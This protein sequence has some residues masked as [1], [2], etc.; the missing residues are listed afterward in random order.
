MPS[1]RSRSSPTELSARNDEVRVHRSMFSLQQYVRRT[2]DLIFP[3]PF[4]VDQMDM[5]VFVL[6]VD[7]PEELQA[8]IDRELNTPWQQAFALRGILHHYQPT[9]D[10]IVVVVSEVQSLYPKQFEDPGVA[11]NGNPG[12]APG[13]GDFQSITA[14]QRELLVMVPLE[15]LGPQL[16]G[17]AP[18]AR[19]DQLWYV[20]YA[21]NDLPPAV[22]AGRET[23]GYPK[24]LAQFFTNPAAEEPQ[25]G[26]PHVPRRIVDHPDD[27]WRHLAIKTYGPKERPAGSAS[28]YRL[29][30]IDVVQ[31]AAE[32]GGEKSEYLKPADADVIA[33]AAKDLFER[34]L[35][36]LFLRQ[37]LDPEFDSYASYQAVVSGSLTASDG[38]GGN[39]PTTD[40]LP[41]PQR[42]R[43]RF[44]AIGPKRACLAEAFGIVP[45]KD[46]FVFP[47]A[48]FELKGQK[49][50]VTRGEIRWDKP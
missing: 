24:L 33:K 29:D 46:G 48:V 44:P 10:W 14:Q 13:D 12:A 28:K 35:E 5:L 20:P 45:G 15:D 31:I 2:G 4:V 18:L 16:S 3:P 49:L 37:Y 7:K 34:R 39:L 22:L 42:Y 40:P 25:L 21:L 19:S 26:A 43:L 32:R 27:G 47:R 9:A 1:E 8:L 23:F 36:L 30:L 50:V 11:P 38:P 6:K 17:G 41:E